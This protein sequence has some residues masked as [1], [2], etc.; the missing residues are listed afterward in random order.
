MNTRVVSR[1]I[2]LLIVAC[3]LR[4][5]TASA[6]NPQRGPAVP[7]ILRADTGNSVTTLFIDGVNFGTALPTVT[8]AD[9]HLV[10]INSSDTHIEAMLPSWAGPGSYTLVVAAAAGVSGNARESA[11]FEVTIGAVGPKGDTGAQ[12]PT[13]A[14]G[15]QG[16]QGPAGATGPSGPAG[17]AGAAGAQ[18]IAGPAGAQG[19]AGPQGPAGT[20][21]SF[22]ALSGLACT[23]NNTAGT[24]ALSYATNG[25]ALLRCVL[26]PPPP[27]PLAGTYTL[28]PQIHFSCVFGFANFNI[29]SFVFSGSP[30][31]VTVFGGPEE[32]S[33]SLNGA[34]FNVQGTG[35][36]SGPAGNVNATYR[37][38]G[39]FDASANT[40]TGTFLPSFSGGGVELT[41]CNG[42]QF[43]VTGTHL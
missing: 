3:L 34:Q 21:A 37:L 30:G 7:E 20:L 12:G 29:A 27:S 19:P 42:R 11:P 14:T 41:D 43:G 31:S 32:M 36:V 1:I 8:L 9:R 2:A 22:D 33:G 38:S 17:P 18:G 6:Q 10:V 40:W 28:S 23:R 4:V 16:P 39:T 35:T 13:G 26:P 15:P 5:A 24:I 25:D